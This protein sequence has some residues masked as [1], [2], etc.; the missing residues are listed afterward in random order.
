MIRW[1]QGQ[2]P[3]PTELDK[4]DMHFVCFVEHEGTLYELDGRRDT[5]IPHGPTTI[6]SLL[7][8]A[9]GVIQGKFMAADPSEHRFTI[10]ALTAAS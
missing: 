6:H 9:A 3:V 7:A 1:Q 5:P 10:V 8:D 2:T 4:V